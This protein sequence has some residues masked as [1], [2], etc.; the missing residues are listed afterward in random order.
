MV[1]LLIVAYSVVQASR[2]F[3]ASVISQVYGEL[4]HVHHTF[5]ENPKLRP[6]FFHRVHIGPDD[7]DYMQAR[8]VAEMY[9]DIFEQIL[10]MR[11]YAPRKLRPFFEA[12]IREMLSGSPFLLEYLTETEN[13]KL[14]Y[15]E[16]LVEIV[17]LANAQESQRRLREGISAPKGLKRTPDG[18]VSGL[19]GQDADSPRGPGGRSRN[20]K[21]LLEA[22]V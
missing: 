18:T 16:R 4:H 17:R 7:E 3:R 11:P 15:P 6:Y 12:Y 20:R 13:Q 14:L 8:G 21:K 10:I 19:L 9:L 5:I 2:A 1:G 22:E